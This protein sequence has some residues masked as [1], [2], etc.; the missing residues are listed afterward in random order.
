MKARKILDRVLLLVAALLVLS[1]ATILVVRSMADK[2][3]ESS[4]I[5]VALD[6]TA[7]GERKSELEVANES[8]EA[9]LEVDHLGRDQA[10]L[11][12][13]YPPPTVEPLPESVE[14][15]D[16]TAEPVNDSQAQ[17]EGQVTNS[18]Q[19]SD[20]EIF[21][22]PP[23]GSHDVDLTLFVSSVGGVNLRSEAST[24]SEIKQVIAYGN[25]VHVIGVV[26]EWAEVKLSGGERGF[27]A[28]EYL[29]AIKPPVLESSKSTSTVATTEVSKPVQTTKAN[30]TAASTTTASTTTASTTTAPVTTTAPITS[31]PAP[32]HGPGTSPDFLFSI[33]NP[34]PNYQGRVVEVEDREVLEGLVMG[35]FGGDYKGAVL[36]AQ[37]IRDSMI[38]DGIY[39]T[40]RIAQRWGYSAKV[41]PNISNATKRAVAYVFDEGGSAVQHSIY[42]FYASS[43]TYSP[44]H[45]SQKFI[46]EYGGCRFFSKHSS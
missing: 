36:V 11:I 30:T 29:Q 12:D 33:S 44:W 9:L 26:A 41:R 4:V 28:R 19:L 7:T 3:N 10:D 13:L 2:E 24:T 45:E 6:E 40:T 37:A 1:L 15:E 42:Y 16:A 38:H 18:L 8:E 32:T 14:I 34:N 46:I 35:E 27:L 22:N 31:T 25:S 5:F 39:N 23:S 21:L 20:Y 17:T 43:R